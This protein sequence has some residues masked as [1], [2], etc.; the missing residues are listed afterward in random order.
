MKGGAHA[1]SSSYHKVPLN[2]T[3]LVLNKHTNRTASNLNLSGYG[4]H[5][6]HTLLENHSFSAMMHPHET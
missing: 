3:P 5:G 2:Q 6:N 1:S 4:G